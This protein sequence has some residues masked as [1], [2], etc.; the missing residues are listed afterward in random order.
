MAICSLLF[1]LPLK[2]W[3]GCCAVVY[4]SPAGSRLQ[5]VVTVVAK[6]SIFH[7]HPEQVLAW[8]SLSLLMLHDSLFH[9][10]DEIQK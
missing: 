5:D 9:N 4:D 10:I 1:I 7:L 6:R 2:L 8:F 3:A